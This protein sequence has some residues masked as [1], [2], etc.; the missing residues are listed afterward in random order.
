MRWV[1]RSIG[2]R[3]VHALGFETG[4]TFLLVPLFALILGISLWAALLFDLGA[5]VFF[6]VYTYVFNLAFDHVFGLPASAQRR[7]THRA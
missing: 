4:L 1:G 5:I 2:L 3:I 7:G 6:L